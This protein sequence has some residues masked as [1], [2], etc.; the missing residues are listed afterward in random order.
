M[1]AQP[2]RRGH[3]RNNGLGRQWPGGQETEKVLDKNVLPS[4]MSRPRVSSYEKTKF[5]GGSKEYA[6]K[7]NV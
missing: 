1:H 6:F 3:L 5:I 4:H 7:L 2:G